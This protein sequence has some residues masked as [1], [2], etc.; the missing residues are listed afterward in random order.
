MEDIETPEQ[1]MMLLIYSTLIVPF[2]KAGFRVKLMDDGGHL[3]VQDEREGD[4]YDIHI[5]KHHNTEKRRLVQIDSEG[6]EETEDPFVANDYRLGLVAIDGGSLYKALGFQFIGPQG[7]T[8]PVIVDAMTMLSIK[9]DFD[10]AFE[11][12]IEQ[13]KRPQGD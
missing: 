2:S 6:V 13:M 3:V 1:I 4:E 9:K 8:Q 11:T 12:I 7:K 10:I 5:Y